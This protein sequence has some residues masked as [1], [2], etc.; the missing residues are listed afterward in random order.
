MLNLLTPQIDK[1]QQ[2]A[3]IFVSPGGIC[4][5]PQLAVAFALGVGYLAFRQ[6]RRRGFVRPRAILRALLASR[7]ILRHRSTRADLVYYVVNTFAI[8]GL[9]G[10]G[11]FS[12]VAV[13]GV[14]VHGLDVALRARAP[15][16]LP[17]WT[18]RTGATLVVFLGY[19]FGYYVDHVL[20]HRIPVLW[21]LHKT[22]HSAE[23]L[24][25]LTVFRVHPLDTL[26]FVDMI[27]I[28]IGVLHGVFAYAVGRS[29]PIYALDNSNVIAVACFFLLAQ[30]QHSQFWIPLR[31]LPGRMILSPAHHQIHHSLS[32]EHHDRNFGSFLG[33][34]DW[35]FGTLSVPDQESPGLKFGVA[36]ESTEPHRLFTLL[37]AP[38]VNAVAVLAAAL[39]F[40]RRPKADVVA[41]PGDEQMVVGLTETS[42]VV[43][44]ESASTARA[45]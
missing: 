13:S 14:V 9:I 5:A 22:H 38:M 21:A 12:G 39:P 33:V 29:V 18:L 4:S 6:W 35:M 10:W 31:G 36:Q 19:E 26:M 1:L 30:L 15:C 40:H 43:P 37:V 44:L 27:A 34:W 16:H 24:T 20:K 23:V 32:P 7:R 3:A 42:S 41:I 2:A 28:S 25:P 17:V 11:I 8:S 45:A